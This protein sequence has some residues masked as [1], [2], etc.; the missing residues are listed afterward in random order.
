MRPQCCQEEVRGWSDDEGRKLRIKV[1]G[2]IF[3]ERNHKAEHSEKSHLPHN[4][5]FSI[6]PILKKKNPKL[7]LVILVQ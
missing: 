2:Y 6:I 3:I 5:G 1:D 7:T 4:E